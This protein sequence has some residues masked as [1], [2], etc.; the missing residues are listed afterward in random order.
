MPPMFLNEAL[1]STFV[2]HQDG[3]LYRG[4]ILKHQIFKLVQYFLSNQREQVFAMA[5]GLFYQDWTVVITASPYGYGV[6][7]DVCANIDCN[8]ID[9]FSNT[10]FNECMETI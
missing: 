6:W 9:L 1:V 8:S 7:I 4:L 5:W 10:V 2:F 3:K